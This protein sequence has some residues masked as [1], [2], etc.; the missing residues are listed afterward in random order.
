MNEAIDPVEPW[1][2]PWSHS[3]PIFNLVR[4]ER[5]GSC[6]LMSLTSNSARQ[7]REVFIVRQGI[8]DSAH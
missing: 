2:M 7:A 5:V 8:G 6:A 1:S 4:V 3:F